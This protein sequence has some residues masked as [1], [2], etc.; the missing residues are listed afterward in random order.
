MYLSIQQHDRFRNLLMGF[1]IPYRGYI[2][3]ILMSDFPTKSDFET[4]LFAK[5]ASLQPSDPFFLRTTLSKVDSKKSEKMY[6]A[7]SVAATSQAIVSIDQDMP[8][9]GALNIVTFALTG[10]FSDLYG[11]FSSYGSFCDFAEKYRYARNKL[12]HPGCRTLDDS[13]LVPVLSFVKDICSFL[14][15]RFFIQKSKSDIL[16]EITALQQRRIVI[17]LDKHNLNDTPY[18]DS[19]LVCRDAEI[20]ELKKFLYGNPGDLRKQHS[21][22]IYGYGGV[23]KTA[24]VIELIKQTIQDIVDQ[25]TVNDYAP[26]YMFFFSAKKRQLRVAGETGKIVE[27][28]ISWNFETADELISLIHSS[29]GYDSLRGFHDEGLIIVD[30]LE[31]LAQEERDKVK[32]FIEAQTPTEMQFIITSRNSEEYESN[33][34]LSGFESESGINFIQS[35]IEENTLDLQLSE[36]EIR[37]LLDISKGNTL[38]LVLCLRRLSKKLIDMSGLKADF[39]RV[40]TLKDLKSNTSTLAPN[41]YA[42][43]SDFM[44]KDTFEQIENIFAEPILFYKILKVFAVIH[45]NEGI[46]ISTICLLADIPYPQTEAAIDTLCNYLIIEKNGGVYFLNEFA[47]TYIVQ[48]F[49]PDAE[50]FANLSREIRSRRSQIK[51][52]LDNLEKDMVEKPE[53]AQIMKDWNINSDSDRITS[54]K[55]YD[56]YGRV[57]SECNRSGRHR[58][59]SVMEDFIK[60]SEEC[61]RITAHPFIKFQKA[62]IL[63]LID[64]SNILEARHDG[65]IKQ[66][67]LNAIYNIKTI[68]QYSFIQNTKS[69]AALLWL[70]GQ[71]LADQNQIQESI[72]YLEDGKTAFESQ[73]I[74]DPQYYQCVTLLGWQYLNYYL[75]DR[76]TR[77]S[78][79]QRSRTISRF[80]QENIYSLDKAYKHAMS[81]KYELRKYGGKG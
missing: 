62:R 34:K 49:I 69:Y 10:N 7:F 31:T 46:D 6:N 48:R 53:L 25:T 77:K 33:K 54:A 9:V 72:R 38:V 19:H 68:Y 78:Y 80:L 43:I 23:G 12:D 20:D 3:D 22:C 40:S 17:P 47:E 55:M 52:A 58:I 71:F 64:R 14:D 1:E 15:D 70:Y 65:E 50:T 79:L 5:K 28:Q 67:Y 74:T 61:E 39:S 13:H 24:L 44:Y 18:A 26:K 42:S 66:N 37:D 32:Q 76:P 35:Y 21:R 4:A 11:L 30:N 81:L 45:N 16:A 27:H 73:E 60:E 2:A 75:E 41:A 59:Q 57:N 29:L 8:M 63:Q 51:E 36:R 56:L